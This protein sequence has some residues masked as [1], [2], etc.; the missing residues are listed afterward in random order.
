MNDQASLEFDNRSCRR[1]FTNGSHGI[2]P[3]HGFLSTLP[4]EVSSRVAPLHDYCSQPEHQNYCG[5]EPEGGRAPDHCKH[6]S[7]RGIEV[8]R[9]SGLRQ[10]CVDSV[11]CQTIRNRTVGRKC[12][13]DGR[14]DL[15]DIVKHGLTVC[16]AGKMLAD[17]SS[18]AG[19]EC[20]ER[21]VGQVRF[22]VMT[23]I[24]EFRVTAPGA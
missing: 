23:G 9:S 21:I 4:S 5:S 12:R 8:R 22:N 7:R 15:A 18:A 2:D 3:F 1:R 16:A 11:I 20:I 19:V 13:G 17:G 6:R 14:D 10:D 24:H